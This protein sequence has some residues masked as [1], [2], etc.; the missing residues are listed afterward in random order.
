[1]EVY[2]ISRQ[3]KFASLHTHYLDYLNNV[4]FFV[5]VKSFS[6]RNSDEDTSL[7]GANLS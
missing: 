7:I 4:L 2:C 5:D 6:V 1:M 3:T